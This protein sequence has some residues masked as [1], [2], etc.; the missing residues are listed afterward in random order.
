MNLF[1]FL[2]CHFTSFIY[3]FLNFS[4]FFFCFVLFTTKLCLS[5]YIPMDY[6]LPAS[7][8]FTISWSL[9]KLMYIESVMPS[10]HLIFCHPLLFPSVFPRIRN[11][12]N[13]SALRIRWP[14]YWSLRLSI[15]S[16]KECSGLI[17]FRFYWLD[18][19]S[20]RGILKSLLQLHSSKASILNHS[21][22]FTVQ[23]SHPY[24]TTGKI[25][26]FTLW[27]FVVKVMSPLLNI[28]LKFVISF[29]SR[30]KHF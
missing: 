16:S 29:I 15:S 19:L 10:N 28:L 30:S 3:L 6:S 5:L 25:I 18:H 17:S 14:K 21:A 13:E 12:S 7:P 4:F 1:H 27:T 11:F 2:Q 26:V 9:L 20:V 8:F 23:L 24:M 22:F